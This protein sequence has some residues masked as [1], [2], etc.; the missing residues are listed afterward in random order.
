MPSVLRALIRGAGEG[1]VAT[2]TMSL[3]MLGG[4][5]L[6]LMQTPPP[7]QIT[8]NAER[9]S[10]V[11]PRSMPQPA[12]KLSWLLAHLGFGA[13]CGALYVLAVNRLPLPGLLKGIAY[14][15]A[16]WATNYLGVLPALELYPWPD[17]DSSG[18]VGAMIAAH[19]VYGATLATFSP[20]R[21]ALPGR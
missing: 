7:K 18:R 15:V 4:K 13:A 9:Q 10:D 21:D 11:P 14:G 3:V 19:I 1:V 5:F 12:F 2:G 6:G 20:N 16:V 17:Q 8:A